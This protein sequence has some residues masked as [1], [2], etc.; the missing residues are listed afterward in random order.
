[1]NLAC[2]TLELQHKIDVAVVLTRASAVVGSGE[3]ENLSTVRSYWRPGKRVRV[4]STAY[5][6]S[7]R[8]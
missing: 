7:S 3:N 6:S 8:Q 4:Q 5:F 2:F 1:M